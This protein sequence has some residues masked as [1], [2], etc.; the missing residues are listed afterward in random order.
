M[1]NYLKYGK[2]SEICG[3][4]GYF[5]GEKLHPR[6]QKNFPCGEG[7]SHIFLRGGEKNSTLSKNILPCRLSVVNPD[8]NVYY[9]R[10]CP[11]KIRNCVKYLILLECQF[12]HSGVSAS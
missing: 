11:Q 2:I 5:A 10:N 12:Q 7:N 1:Q 9:M 6:R 4:N 3:I 8:T